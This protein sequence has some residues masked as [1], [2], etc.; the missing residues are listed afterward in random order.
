MI[1]KLSCN[2]AAFKISRDLVKNMKLLEFFSVDNQE[3][4]EESNSEDLAKDVTGFILDDDELYKQK[5]LPLVHSMKKGLDDDA[6][7]KKFLEIVNDG[8]IKYY[9][10][11]D[12]KK[13]P[14]ELFPKSMRQTIVKNLID[15][16]KNTLKKKD[17]KDED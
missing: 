11:E 14:N 10:E 17:K 5:I 2:L 1:G 9:K 15:L 8:C 16:Y 6:L 7:K 13:D 4:P 12:L 3:N